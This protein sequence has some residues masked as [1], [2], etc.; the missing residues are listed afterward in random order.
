MS[1]KEAVEALK[2]AQSQLERVQTAWYDPAD[3]EEAV[4]WAF[5]AFENAVVAVAEKANIKWEKTHW[6]KLDVADKI[7]AK[8][9]V[10]TNVRERLV[11]LNELRKDVAYGEPGPDLAALD[12]EDLVT[13]LE[14][15]INEV[16]GFVET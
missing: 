4:T 7:H 16:A 13:E 1:K 12:L 9:Y 2:R 11:E 14:E 3:A 10:S 5:Y 15:F 8:G 6:N